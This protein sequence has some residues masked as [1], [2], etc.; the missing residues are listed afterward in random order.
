MVTLWLKMSYI[1]KILYLFT[2]YILDKY[3][4]YIYIYTH[5]VEM[6]NFEFSRGSFYLYG[7]VCS[8][9]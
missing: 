8:V 1:F 6:I 3:N 9:F 4:I 2:H 5:R 7:I